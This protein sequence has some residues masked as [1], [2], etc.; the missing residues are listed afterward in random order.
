MNEQ[1]HCDMA[2][3]CE[4]P[5]THIGSKGYIYC[6]EHALARRMSGYESTRKM[7]SWEVHLLEVGRQLPSYAPG[8]KP[9]E[10]R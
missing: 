4:N 1:L 7:R 3:D 10:T 5:V 8:P 6:A 9:K 2:G